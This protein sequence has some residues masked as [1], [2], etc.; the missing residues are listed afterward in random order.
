MSINF[1][2]LIGVVLSSLVLLPGVLIFG[3][4]LINRTIPPSSGE[5]SNS[6]VQNDV[7]IY[8]DAN[9]IA[10]ISSVSE[11]DAMRALGF[12]HAKERL[13]QMEVMRRVAAGRLSEVVGAEALPVD[14]L[15]R[16]IGLARIVERDY[17]KL[18]DTT[19]QVL[20]A[21]SEGVNIVLNEYG[22]RF[23]P[24]LN[25]FPEEV[26][27]WKPEDSF[28]ISK[29]VG[30]TL[31]LSWW[32]DAAYID[33][34]NKLGADAVEAIIPQFD[35]NKKMTIP[36]GKV[37][38]V[39]PAISMVE[40]DRSF[41]KMFGLDGTQV[42]SNNWVVSPA[43]SASNKAMIAND[44]HLAVLHPNLWYFT[45]ISAREFSAA[46]FTIPGAPGVVI[47][48]NDVMAW[49]YTN[50]MA[51]D[52][53]FY[54]ETIDSSGKKYLFDGEWKDFEVIEE[55]IV[56]KD[57][58]DVELEILIN[59][60]GPVINNI[61]PNTLLHYEKPASSTITM[62]WTGFEFSDEP[63]AILK[64]NRSR[65]IAEFI[66][67]V[68]GFKLPGQNFMFADSAGNIGYLCAAR[69]PIRKDKFPT[70]IYDGS[71]SQ[72]D[73]SGFVPYK[74][75]PRII[76][77][78]T[79]YL[80]SANNKVMKDFEYHISN[81]WEPDSR[82]RRI[83][84]FLDR[85]TTFSVNDFEIMQNDIKSVYAEDFV[86]KIIEIFSNVEVTDKNLKTV[87]ELLRQW[88]YEMEAES[89]TPAIFSVFKMKMLENLFLD[90]MGETY[91]KE[92]TFMT[93]I[94][95]RILQEYFN[96]RTSEWIDDKDSDELENF[97]D[98]VKKSL[99]DAVIW[100][101]QNYGKNPS[102]WQWG[103]LHK[104]KFTHPF[105]QGAE[106]LS[107]LFDIGPFEVSGDGTTLSNTEFSFNTP[108]DVKVVASM[109]MIYDFSAR[110]IIKIALPTGQSGH[111]NSEN[112]D[113]LTEGWIKGQ[114]IDVNCSTDDFENNNYELFV[115]KR[116][117]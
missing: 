42:G 53:D 109:R 32:T 5:L 57:S 17:P 28:L 14:K 7:K 97:K 69:L 52:C 91:L 88:D 92:Y 74:K 48:K 106:I 70:Y 102:G 44:P 116:G 110:D 83:N 107:P 67:A 4:I 113:N 84:Q 51:D 103:K 13:F 33:L 54:Y 100:L 45:V 56:V 108:Y 73:W 19:K 34:A 38:D 21:Y 26:E 11:E 80:A 82:I 65:N 30:W 64:V 60:R 89:Q 16:T 3:Y 115:L 63:G 6:L 94:S 72:N 24:E 49:G 59:H 50:V 22:S 8:T 9:G 78:A 71:K 99:V 41:R 18:N 10:Y 47:G 87:L 37:A 27:L 96:G 98:I 29:L 43:K 76:N 23:A 101:E 81:I 104:L 77:P 112:Y 40:V 58:T 61:R 1:K 90:E 39:S 68:E 114:Y 93:N 46:G 95:H 75:M 105:S 111:F 85:D 2:V 55:K 35:E 31:N 62:R 15:F 12:Q 20:Q 86:P 36:K 25:L 117:N 79:N 66:E